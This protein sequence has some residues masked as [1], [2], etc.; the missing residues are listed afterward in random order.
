ML[1]GAIAIEKSGMPLAH[2]RVFQAVA[3]AEQCVI[4]SREVGR[5]ATGLLLEGYATKGFHDKAKSCPWGPMAGFVMADP[6]FTKNPDM[7]GQ[8][9]DLLKALKA[10]CGEMPLYITDDRR[11]D[12]ELRLR[13]IVRSGG[14]INE[15]VYTAVAPNGPPMDFV[16][17]RT[18][19]GPGANGKVLWAV[20]YGR[21]EVRLSN[22]LTGANKAGPKGDLL[23]AMAMVDVACPP[24]VKKTYRGATTGDY[25]LWA[26]FPRR[27]NYSRQGDDQRMVP[28]SDRFRQNIR[29]FIEHEDE[30]RGNLTPR[31]AKVREAINNGVRT[32]GYNGGDVV[33]HSDE[34]GRPNVSSI[35]FPCIAF[36]PGGPAAYCL[37]NVADLKAFI[38]DIGFRYVLGLNPG[39]QGQLGISVSKG[40]AYTV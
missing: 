16:L 2:G 39:W 21:N 38:G 36:V 7:A 33:H 40:G 8:R 4:A 25:D 15:M 9:G 12:L 32:I 19:N 5:F 14:N 11:K 31:I 26:V 29:A 1:R 35:D 37:E 17:R 23:P 13:T 28:G 30:H 3:D 24:E 10:G 6:R 22:S 27:E 18:M 34:A 20:L